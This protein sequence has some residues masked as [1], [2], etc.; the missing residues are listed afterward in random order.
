MLPK[1]IQRKRAKGWLAPAKTKYVG[2]PTQWG[3]LFRVGSLLPVDGTFV[4]AVLDDKPLFQV[5]TNE[6]AIELYGQWLDLMLEREPDFLDPLRDMD[7]LMC[8]CPLG[9][10][11]HVDVILERLGE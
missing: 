7:F 5:V 6:Q 3:N 11:C 9:T 4:E 10:A 1:R 2:R 8:W